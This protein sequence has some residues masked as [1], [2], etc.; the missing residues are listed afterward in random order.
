MGQFF[1]MYEQYASNFEAAACKVSECLKRDPSFCSFLESCQSS[2]QCG[3]MSLFSLLLL[4]L[5]R[6]AAYKEDLELMLMLTP[7]GE[8]DRVHLQRSFSRVSSM[9]TKLQDKLIRAQELEE[10]WD[11]QQMTSG[12]FSSFLEPNRR[13]VIQDDLSVAGDFGEK[14]RHVVLFNSGLLTLGFAESVTEEEQRTKN[15]RHKFD[16]KML[17][18]LVGASVTLGASRVRGQFCVIFKSPEGKNYSLFFTDRSK[19]TQWYVLCP[20]FQLPQLPAPLKFI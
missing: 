4:P 3:G 9:C 1:K 14:H 7:D 6:I 13:I 11:L 15:S 12:H 16:F 5:Q 19:Q 20:T 8:E 2:H 10:L 17:H 18:Q